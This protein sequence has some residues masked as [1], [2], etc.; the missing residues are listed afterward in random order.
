MHACTRRTMSGLIAHRA[1]D[2][3]LSHPVARGERRIDW[4]EAGEAAVVVLN[5][6]HTPVHNLPRSDHDAVCGRTHG[7]ADLGGKVD[8]AMPR[9]PA[10]SWQP[11][12]R[13]QV[14]RSDRGYI[15]C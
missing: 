14:K 2:V 15:R 6:D 7:C 13:H 4:L 5:G 10:L 12:K 3:S 8:A 11:G 1:D 9:K